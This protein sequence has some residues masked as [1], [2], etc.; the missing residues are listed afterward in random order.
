MSAPQHLKHDH[1]STA[2]TL[3]VAGYAAH[4][5]LF[6]RTGHGEAM[7]ARA[8]GRQF[9]LG[10]HRVDG[11]AATLTDLVV[12]A[13]CGTWWTHRPRTAATRPSSPHREWLGLR[14]C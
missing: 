11:G 3:D 5:A 10:V 6:N 14:T 8:G 4:V 9:R 13:Q 12:L 1:A 7:A 2:S